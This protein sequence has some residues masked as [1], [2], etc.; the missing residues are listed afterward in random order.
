MLKDKMKW[1]NNSIASK[2][3]TVYVLAVYN[4]YIKFTEEILI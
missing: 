2:W 3:T 4:F 1:K